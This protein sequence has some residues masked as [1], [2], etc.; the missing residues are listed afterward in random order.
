MKIRSISS[1]IYPIPIEY[2]LGWEYV[3][4]CFGVLL[5]KKKD[6]S[7]HSSIYS[8]EAEIVIFEYL[9]CLEV[10]YKD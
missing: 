5:K 8:A 6:I 3:C 4:V 10:D 1:E 2:F 9:V 7:I